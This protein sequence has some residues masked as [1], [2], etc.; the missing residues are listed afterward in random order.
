MV[1]FPP[2]VHFS[3]YISTGCG[4]RNLVGQ[5]IAYAYSIMSGRVAVLMGTRLPLRRENERGNGIVYL[6]N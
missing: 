5:T 1:T 3:G 2:T 6:T 4:M